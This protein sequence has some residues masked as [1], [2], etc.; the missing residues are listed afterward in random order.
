MEKNTKGIILAAFIFIAAAV[1][2]GIT[3]KSSDD[4]SSSGA[5][6]FSVAGAKETIRILS[7]SENKEL[8]DI[9]QQCTKSTKVNIEI[10]Y[11]GSIDIMRELQN[12]A[13]DYDAVWPASS[14]WISIGDTGHLVKNAE[15]ISTTP[16]VFGIKQ[17]LAQELG[18]VGKEV[19]V[20]DILSAIENDKMT[21]CMTSATQSNSGASAYI[22]FLYALLDKQDSMTAQ[23]LEDEQLQEKIT[24]LLSGIDRSSGSSDWLK[25]MFLNGSYDAMVNYECLMI[26]ANQELEKQGRETLYVVYPYDGLCLADSPLGYVDHDDKDKQKAFDKIQEYLLGDEA[27]NA[28]QRTGRRTGYT[29]IKEENKEVFRADWGIDTE[30]VLSPITMPD[31][32]TL[33][34]ALNMY[35]SQFRKPSLTVYCLDFSGSMSGDGN[36][37]LVEAMGQ[38]L[39]KENAEKNYLQANEK[40]VDIVITFSGGVKSVYVVDEPTEANLRE[41]YENIKNEDCGGGTDMYG[42]AKEALEMMTENYELEDYTPAIIIMTDGKSNGSIRYADFETSYKTAEADIPVF[43]IMFGDADEKE[44]GALAELTN[45]R[46]FDGR[47]DLI[48]AF[49]SAKGYN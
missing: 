27:Q 49:R 24:S 36:E 28:I 37:Q 44:V 2:I 38:I 13:S 31:A 21:F 19:S 40:E 17:K 8:E 32:E 15:S 3:G 47:T 33:M 20:K 10:T 23:D 26:S 29:G 7:G 45:A 41:L 43:S 25:E 48:S 22:G 11:K 34:K 39:L 5:Q 42:A 30:R 4:E 9:L 18:F 16:V 46:T 6:R 35:Q 14:L 1:V 12:G